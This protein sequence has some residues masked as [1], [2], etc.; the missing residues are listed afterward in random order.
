M[1]CDSE[2]KRKQ[3]EQHLGTQTTSVAVYILK[4]LLQFCRKFFHASLAV[5]HCSHAKSGTNQWPTT[6]S[7]IFFKRTCKRRSRYQRLTQHRSAE[8]NSATL[9]FCMPSSSSFKSHTRNDSRKKCQRHRP[10]KIP[11]DNP[12]KELLGEII[13]FTHKLRK[14]V[15]ISALRSTWLKPWRSLAVNK[16]SPQP[17]QC[18]QLAVYVGPGEYRQKK[19]WDFRILDLQWIDLF[20]SHDFTNLQFTLR[21]ISKPSFGEVVGRKLPFWWGVKTW[22][23]QNR[24][25]PVVSI[26]CNIDCKSH[27]PAC[28]HA[29]HTFLQCMFFHLYNPYFERRNTKSLSELQ[30]TTRHS[31]NFWMAGLKNRGK[32]SHIG[33]DSAFRQKKTLFQ[34]KSLIKLSTIDIHRDERFS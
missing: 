6:R 7:C 3:Q 34:K 2:K 12:P 18:L 5:S 27:V 8:I 14:S 24:S 29:K 16:P 11:E 9:A 15:S 20:D 31:W 30:C 22:I 25:S 28:T 32:N 1:T 23:S 4:D 21:R 17:N 19:Y 33:M 13:R 26:A 10:Q